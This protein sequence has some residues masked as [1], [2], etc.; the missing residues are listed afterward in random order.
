MNILTK[1]LAIIMLPL[2]ILIILESTGLFSLALPFDKVFIGAI[3]MIALQ[4]LNLILLK[5]NKGLLRFINIIT[6]L[7]FILPAVA[8]I[9]STIM[10]FYLFESVPLIIGIIMFI[11]ALYAL[12]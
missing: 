11:E 4:L 6:T 3:L 2:S 1:L 7:V 9:L 12:H 5:I 8:Y 10:G